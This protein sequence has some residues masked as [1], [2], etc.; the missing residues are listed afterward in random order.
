VSKLTTKPQPRLSGRLWTALTLG[1]VILSA[2]CGGGSSPQASTSPSPRQMTT[3][4]YANTPSLLY[5]PTYIADAQG[6]FAKHGITVNWVTTSSQIPALV[7]GQVQFAN[8]GLDIA[9]IDADKGEPTP[10]IVAVQQHNSLALAIRSSEAVPNAVYPDSVKALKGKTLV[11]T[12]LVGGAGV[13][14]QLVLAGAG[15]VENKDVAIITVPTPAAVLATLQAGRADAGFMFPPFLQQGIN[16]GIVVPLVDEAKGQGPQDL[17]TKA[18]G[19]GVISTFNYIN[20]NKSLV[21]EF[22]AAITEAEAFNR[23]VAKNKAALLRILV[24][25]TGVTD[26]AALSTALESEAPLAQPGMT[27]ARWAIHAGLL[28]SVGSIQNIPPCNQIM[29]TDVA[30]V[31]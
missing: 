22:V 21:K 11:T 31:G 28:K 9:V 6:Y 2:A 7:S 12:A 20:A 5:L 23:D 15:L 1:T 29:A 14:V 30:P 4:S 27:C 17:A 18:Y 19:G 13:F 3:I 8:A 16:E 26:E 24:Q 10:A 25:Y